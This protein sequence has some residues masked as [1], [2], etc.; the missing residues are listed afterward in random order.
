MPISNPTVDIKKITRIDEAS[1]TITYIGKAAPSTE[2]SEAKWSI[3][4]IDTSV[5]GQTII[6]FADGNSNE[7]NIYDNRASLTYS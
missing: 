3:Q 5:A 6:L 7:D 4:R 1:A 2:T